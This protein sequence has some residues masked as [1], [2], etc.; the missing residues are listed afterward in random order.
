MRIMKY[1]Q[2]IF[3]P[4]LSLI[5]FSCANMQEPDYTEKDYGYVQF[6]LYKAASYTK[7]G[8][9]KVLAYLSDATKIRV[10][11]SDGEKTINQ[12]LVLNSF[13]AESAEFGLRSDK[14]KLLAGNYRIVSYILYGKMDEQIYESTP[15]SS[16]LMESEFSIVPGG[17][18]VH[19]LLAETQQ[20]GK[21]KF[22]LVKDFVAATKASTR[23]YTF[24]EIKSVDIALRNSQDRV[25]VFKALPVKFSL[26]FAEDSD[27][28]KYENGYQTSVSVCDTTLSILAGEYTVD[29]YVTYD[30]VKGKSLLERNDNV[31]LKGE[32]VTF[33]VEDNKTTDAKV[34]VRL[35]ESDEYLQ[36]YY[37]L[38]AIWESLDGPNWYYSGEDYAT[39]INWNFDKDI[40]LWG[41]QPGVSLHSNGRVALINVSD[42]GFRGTLPAAISQLTE[43]TEL[44]LGT[45]NDANQNEFDETLN[46]GTANRFE[47]HKAYLSGKYVPEQMSEPIARALKEHDIVIPEVSLYETMKEDQIIDR[48]TG[49]SIPQLKDAAVGKLY[50]GLTAIDPAIWT[51]DKLERLTVANGLLKE[52]PKKPDYITDRDEGFAA[53]TDLEIYNCRDLKNPQ[54]ALRDMPALISVNLSQNNQKWSSEEANELL[55]SLASGRS[56]KKIQILY[57]NKSN[58]THV[59]G[60]VLRNMT[61]L[62]LL[63]L[64]DNKITEVTAFGPEINLVQLHLN[65]NQ[66]ESLSRGQNGEA[67]CGMADVETFSVRNNKIR[68]FP[69]IFDAKSLYGMASVDFS[70]NDIANFEGYDDKGVKTTGSKGIYVETLTLANNPIKVFPDYFKETDSKIAYINMRGCQLE[71]FRDSSFCYPNSVYLT[72][73]DLSYNRLN[74]LPKD[75]HAGNIPYLYGLDISYNKFSIFPYEQFDMAGLTVFAIRGQ[76]DDKGE[77]CLTE[78]PTG[79]YQHVGL[80]GLY[81][82]SNDIREVNDRISTLCYYLDISDN[83]NIV[84]NASDVCYDW[85]IGMYYLI[86]DKTQT[87]LNCDLMLQ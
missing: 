13:N 7:A 6:K 60:N 11:I 62:G 50:N 29:Y 56:A 5:L 77:R 68:Q 81:L 19:D 27:K 35:D 53:L 55:H 2:M 57:M 37:A 52:F 84:F 24:D 21:I 73:F 49:R 23:K 41:D 9:E 46:P 12:S 45:H 15:S 40:D 48:E 76:R 66:I 17:L 47:R 83:P 82:G 65:N 63:D 75:F 72:S 59:D 22:T 85:Q 71:S 78:W 32:I 39:G 3:L 16:P 36:D 54:D 38:K 58:L 33:D 74:D 31:R 42:F 14:M 8:D 61:S 70:Y 86:Y 18:C 30:D 10:T 80:R 43:L 67:F 20:R 28:S 69:D 4:V 26:E 44:Y 34:P 87:I 25:T 1:I 64:S 51:L 79:V